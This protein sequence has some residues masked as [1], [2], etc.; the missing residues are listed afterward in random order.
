M[1]SFFK[2][3]LML[4]MVSA[5]LTGQGCTKGPDAQTIAASQPQELKIWAVVDDAD[6]FMP[7]IQAYQQ[8]HPHITISYKRF[9]LEEYEDVL[10]NY[11]AED[12]GPDIF[13]IHNTWV[14]KY[15]SKIEPMPAYTKMVYKFVTGSVTSRK[16]TLELRNEKSV[17]LRELKERYPDTVYKD[18]TRRVNTA[19]PGQPAFYEDKILAL[20][21]S[22][23]T[24]AMY[25]NKDMLNAAGI[26]TIPTS[27]DRFQATM[28]RL[29][30]VDTEGNI[31]QAGAAMGEADNVERATDILSALMM[32][33]GT[34]MVDD[35]GN[36]TF[37]LLPE[38]LSGTR[39]E[40]P[41]VQAL[42]FYMDFANENKDIYSWN[43]DMPNSLDAFI[44]GRLAYFFGY[45]YHLP[46]IKARAPKL[47][48]AIAKLPQIDG[49]KVVN[50]ANYWVWTVSK[51]SKYPETAWNFINYLAQPDNEKAFLDA[52]KRPPAN[53]ALIEDY[54]EDEELGV[55]ASQILTS[56]SWYRGADS[57][58]AEQA[59]TDL[60]KEAKL[61][62][63]EKWQ[64][65][66]RVTQEKVAQTL[67]SKEY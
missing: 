18:V 47:N 42:R 40:L 43:A 45:S 35:N 9:R 60:I 66:M 38:A 49:N 13:L 44:Q 28:S 5:L 6:Q 50:Y 26:P 56:Q 39:N 58:A 32:Q 34:Q 27:W 30:K 53:K 24:L 8:A 3:A 63:Q 16:E 12:R 10:L 62:P 46:L 67:M 14:G 61:E 36:P 2:R 31:L 1:R 11:M 57:D 65:L 17:T 25:V 33:N 59:L 20:P 37:A 54:L 52:A 19:E 51:K 64:S 23:D 4:L 7:L 15:Q 41:S 21:I 22:V 55:F 48:L 29:V